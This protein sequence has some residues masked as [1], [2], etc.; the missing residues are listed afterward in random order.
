MRDYAAISG[1][2][3]LLPAGQRNGVNERIGLMSPSDFF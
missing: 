3:S 2:R 1:G